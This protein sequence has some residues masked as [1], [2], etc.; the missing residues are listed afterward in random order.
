MLLPL[1]PGL[2]DDEQ[3]LVAESLLSAGEAHGL[4]G[5]RS[6]RRDALVS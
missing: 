2:T 5:F 3:R 6:A 4:R 1:F